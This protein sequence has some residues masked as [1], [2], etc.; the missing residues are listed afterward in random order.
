M[1]ITIPLILIMSITFVLVFLFVKTIDKRIWLTF[2]V[3]LVFTPLVYF[4]A[5]YPMINIF[6]NYHHQKQFSSEIWQDKPSLRYELSDDMMTS[7]ILIGQSKTAIESLLGTHEWLSW[8]DSKKDYD[9]NKWNFGLGREPGAFNT[10]KECLE[11]SFK[12]NK[13]IDLRVYKEEQKGDVKE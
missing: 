5:V 1:I 8:D 10:K 6:S 7:E 3:S 11:L 12:N 9:T 13:V 2:L 4:Y